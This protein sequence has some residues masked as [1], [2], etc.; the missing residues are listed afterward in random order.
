MANIALSSS[1]KGIKYILGIL[2]LL[3]VA[4]AVLTNALVRLGIGIEANPLLLN[5]AGSS[6]FLIIKIL[7]VLLA[8]FILWDIHRRK[9]RLAFWTAAVFILVYG[10]IVVWNL[11]LLL[12]G[13]P[14]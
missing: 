13:S 1:R 8:V 3:D 6:K 7:G 10:G 2:I 12:L 11:R 14:G 4:D 5:L 9:P